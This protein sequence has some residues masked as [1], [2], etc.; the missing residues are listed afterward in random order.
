MSWQ[1][2][3]TRSG[4]S[5]LGHWNSYFELFKIKSY[6]IST[7]YIQC[8]AFLRILYTLKV[9]SV[10]ASHCLWC[11]PP[12][13]RRRMHRAPYAKQLRLQM[14]VSIISLQYTCCESLH[15]NTFLI[16]CIHISRLRWANGLMVTSWTFPVTI[17][18]LPPETW[19]RCHRLQ[20]L[21][22]IPLYVVQQHKC[23]RWLP[24]PFGKKQ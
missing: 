18:Q 24:S 17:Q 11:K 10:F 20:S 1:W 16:S 7:S 13:Q 14:S 23:H 9:S 19:A 6:S 15:G 8:Q 4:R 21:P 3:R 22:H 5:D 12:D 2:I